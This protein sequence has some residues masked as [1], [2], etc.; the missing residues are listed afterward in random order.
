MAAEA[1]AA[2][3][4]GVLRTGQ[5]RHRPRRRHERRH[6]AHRDGKAVPVLREGTDRPR[7]DRPGRPARG[8]A[9]RLLPRQDGHGTGDHRRRI[10]G[11]V[12]PR[13]Q[14][15]RNGRARDPDDGPEGPGGAQRPPDRHRGRR[16]RDRRP[17]EAR[18]VPPDLRRRARRGEHPADD[19]DGSGGRGAEAPQGVRAVEG[20]G[21]DRVE[22][23]VREGADAAR[24]RADR[25]VP[26]V[27]PPAAG[28][29]LHRDPRLPGGGEGRRA[30]R[31]QGRGGVQD[32]RGGERRPCGGS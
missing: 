24:R 1:V 3:E 7:R 16:V 9:G 12:H 20:S 2:G 22:Q 6:R 11:D 15:R 19:R 27:R 17:E 31:R 14:R 8:R 10:D 13:V 4:Q 25:R 23:G 5:R 28:P 26:R 29:R 32:E 18:R 30:G 21:P